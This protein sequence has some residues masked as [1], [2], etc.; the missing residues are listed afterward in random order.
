MPGHALTLERRRR[1][2]GFFGKLPGRGDFV[3]RYLPKSFLEPWDHWLQTAI[4]KSRHQLGDAWREYYCTSPIWRF[5]L[6]AGLCGAD[7][8]A[9]VLMPSV[10]RV[11]R[12]YS[13]VIA[14]PLTP[15]WPLLTL[16]TV[17]EAWFQAAEQLALAGLAQDK[18]DL[19]AF[20]EQV[21]AL[22]APPNVSLT[23]DNPA[24]DPAQHY[25]WPETLNQ[26]QVTAALA[27]DQLRR[28]FHRP[29]LWWT[30]GSDRI[31]RCLLMCDGLPPVEGFAALLAGD[32]EK[33]GWTQQLLAGVACPDEPSA[34][35][36][37]ASL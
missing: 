21:D 26:S 14:A 2:A 27:G 31:N 3:G 12:Y 11:N 15:D 35:E 18:I 29:S 19:E 28:V 16:P 37:K 1:A 6:S 23:E 9:G 24:T 30:E 17:G 7:G 36:E 4:A 22:G 8:Y 10:D 32:W 34:A 20:S 5:A 13:L 33:W 25:L